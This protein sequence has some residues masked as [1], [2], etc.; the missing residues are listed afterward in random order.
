MKSIL[1]I[2]LTL[3]TIARGQIDKNSELFIALKKQD[4]VFFERGFNQCDIDYLDKTISEDLKFFHDQGGLQ[5]RKQ[6]F[7]N[8]K[9]YI[10]SKLEKKP[11]RKLKKGSLVV[12][13]LYNNGVLYGAIQNGDH[14]FYLREN[15]KDDEWTSSA[16]FTHVWI[17]DNGSWILTEVL[18]Y[19]H[20]D[21]STKNKG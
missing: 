20:Q 14:N 18:S 6:F 8:T 3:S 15:G 5:N 2:L 10:C 9:K 21:P 17:L 4:S 16:K 7:E 19:D 12:Y 1:I 11:I 13:P